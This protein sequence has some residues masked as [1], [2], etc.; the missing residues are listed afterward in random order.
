VASLFV[1]PASALVIDDFSTPAGGQYVCEGPALACSAGDF[2]SAAASGAIGGNRDLYVDR[3]G[4]TQTVSLGANVG[5]SGTLTFDSGSGTTGTGQ[6]QW[7]GSDAT[8]TVDTDGLTDGA[9][10]VDLT[11]GG[12]SAFLVKASG[13]ISGGTIELKVYDY[14]SGTAYSSG[15]VALA[16]G[17]ANYLILFSAFGLADF[18]N[19]GAITLDITGPANFDGSVDIVAAVPEPGSLLLIGTGL[20]GLGFVGRHLRRWPSARR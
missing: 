3:T 2:S 18:T 13:D 10:G 12:N 11:V 7:D 4:G 5:G 20:V 15:S 9:G 17:P 6:V 19:V 1:F 14:T 8:S 16:V